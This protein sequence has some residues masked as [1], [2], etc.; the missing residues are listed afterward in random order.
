[1]SNH[2]PGPM[3]VEVGENCVHV[4]G[5]HFVHALMFKTP[6][7]RSE[8]IAMSHLFAAAPRMKAAI[9]RLIGYMDNGGDPIAYYKALGELRSALAEAN[10]EGDK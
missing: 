5:E 1:M 4:I 8:A 3:R 7:E 10:G 2:T 9:E 6:G